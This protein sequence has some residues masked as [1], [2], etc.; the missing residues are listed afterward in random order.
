MVIRPFFAVLVLFTLAALA[1]ATR[2]GVH[3]HRLCGQA[4]N[5]ALCQLSSDAG[6]TPESYLATEPRS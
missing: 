1:E 6:F 4:Q 3:V 2:E 5:P